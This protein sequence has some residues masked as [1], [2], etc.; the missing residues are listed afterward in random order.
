MEKRLT[1]QTDGG[2]R[3]NPGPSALGVVIKDQDKK[4]V[5]QKGEY[6]GITTNNVAEYT[7]LL[8]ALSWVKDH[9]DTTTLSRI[10][11]FADSQLL[12]SQLNGIYKIKSPHIRDLLFNIRAAEQSL[13]CKVVYAHVRREQNKEAD[14][15]VNIALDNQLKGF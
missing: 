1:I 2:S 10:D 15:M 6:L 14:R 4:V 5:Y 7:A 9:V 11:V 8:H 3:G 12:I 13:H